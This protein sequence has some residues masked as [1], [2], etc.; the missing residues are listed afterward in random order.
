MSKVPITAEHQI[1]NIYLKIRI[2]AIY[3]SLQLLL[4]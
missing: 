3:L 4:L 1:L 2:S